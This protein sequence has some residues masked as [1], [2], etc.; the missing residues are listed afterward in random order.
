LH[1]WLDVAKRQSLR[2]GG[3]PVGCQPG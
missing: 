3:E 2:G 1:I